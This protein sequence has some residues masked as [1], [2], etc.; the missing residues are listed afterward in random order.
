MHLRHRKNITLVGIPLDLGAEALGV[1]LGPTAFRKRNIIEKLEHSGLIV[2]DQGDIECA[3]RTQLNPGSPDKPYSAEIVRINEIAASMVEEAI[4]DNTIPLILGGDHSINLGAFSGAAA[5]LGSELGMIYLDAHGDI[6]TTKTSISHNIHGMHLASLMGFGDQEL[7]N[8]HGHGA[9]LNKDNLLHVGGSDF[10]QGELDLIKRENL[11][12][13]TMFDF[14]KDGL[15]PLI[16]MID[17]LCVKVPNVWVSLDLDC[18]DATYAPGVGIPS[19][20]GFTYRE[21]AAITEYIGKNCNVVG[22]DIVEYNPNND[23]DDKTGDLG[24]ELAAKLL[25]TNYSWYTTYMDRQE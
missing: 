4:R 14:L 23:I 13:F 25:G 24:I 18:I 21:I 2:V 6:N 3:D 7:V 5:V 10:D 8:V 17:V 11:R 12:C 15:A 22:I 9:K 20:G 1:D 16:K 19:R